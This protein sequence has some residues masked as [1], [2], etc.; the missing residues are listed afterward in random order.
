MLKLLETSPK[1]M[2]PAGEPA[3]AAPGRAAKGRLTTLPPS[4]RPVAA[5]IGKSWERF[6]FGLFGVR[7]KMPTGSSAA[8]VP[9]GSRM[10]ENAGA[11]PPFLLGAVWKP[12]PMSVV[13][14]LML[15][16]PAPPHWTPMPS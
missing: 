12:W 7:L 14:L 6:R 2:P 13:V 15:P 16:A 3:A 8:T 4:G 10:P 9:S 5:E 11:M 1:E